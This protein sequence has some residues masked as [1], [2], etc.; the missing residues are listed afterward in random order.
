MALCMCVCVKK[1]FD[2]KPGIPE[3]CSHR[4]RHL[5]PT[6]KLSARGAL[7]SCPCFLLSLF[8]FGVELACFPFKLKCI[9]VSEFKTFL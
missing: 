5:V 7:Y 2:F 8:I 3:P 9:Q 4:F 6:L 1:L